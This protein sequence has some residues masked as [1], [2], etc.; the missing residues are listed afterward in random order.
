MWRRNTPRHNEASTG[1]HVS[2]L[3]V[4]FSLLIPATDGDLLLCELGLRF[5]HMKGEKITFSMFPFKWWQF[6]LTTVYQVYTLQTNTAGVHHRCGTEKCLKKKKRTKRR[7]TWIFTLNNLLWY[8]PTVTDWIFGGRW[9]TK[10]TDNGVHVSKITPVTAVYSLIFAVLCTIL[11]V[12]NPQSS[13]PVTC[14]VC[15]FKGTIQR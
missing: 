9:K 6:Y 5:M 11:V 12:T 4:L 14:W 1:Y 3:C 15:S 10:Q 8:W 2:F 7:R 13:I